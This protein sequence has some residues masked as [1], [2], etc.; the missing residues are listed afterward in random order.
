MNLA[1]MGYAVPLLAR[2]RAAD[3]TAI[4]RLLKSLDV[5]NAWSEPGVF[6]DV[7]NAYTASHRLINL[8][9]GLAL[10]RRAG[11][12]ADDAAQTEILQHV[13]YQGET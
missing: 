13:R 2:G 10:Y 1:Y 8:L 3:L 11:G 9:S 5:Q 6:R 12:P 7:W 4:R